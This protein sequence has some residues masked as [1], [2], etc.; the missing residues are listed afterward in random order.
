M[1]YKQFSIEEREKIQEMWWER[2]SIRF[3]A[4]VLTRSPSSVSRELRRNFP[5]KH[6]VYAPRL[7]HQRALAH[8]KSRGRTDRLK[9][10]VIRQYVT[11]NLK[12]GWSPEQISGRLKADGLGSISHEAIYQFVYA[13]VSPASGLV[14]SAYEDLRPYL[15]RRRK[16]RMKKGLRRPKR[17]SYQRGRSIDE[18]PAVV[19]ARTRLGDWEGDTVVSKDHRPGLNT[20]VERV[21]GY[22]CMTKLTGNTAEATAQAVASRLKDMPTHTL[23]LDNGPENSHWQKIEAETNLVCFFAHP[24]HSWERGVNENANGLI[25]EYFPKGT[26][27]STIQETKI[28]AVERLLNSRPRKRL[29]FRTPLEVF[30]VALRS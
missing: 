20:L 11:E 1:K 5:P 17:L 29:D 2:Q 10:E 12:Q 19:E 30:S 23:T 9:N 16:R 13:R 27:F 8:R 6:Q 3:I 26:D 7:A 18:R 28:K 15:R 25:R 22:L 24:Y 14:Y 21:S 4:R